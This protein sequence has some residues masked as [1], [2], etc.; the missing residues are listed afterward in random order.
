MALFYAA[1][2][3]THPVRPFRSIANLARSRYESRMEMSLGNLLRRIRLSS[4]VAS[5]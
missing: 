5:G 2:Y 1:S 4:D 3:A